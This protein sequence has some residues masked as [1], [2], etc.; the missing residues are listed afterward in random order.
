MNEEILCLY[1]KYTKRLEGQDKVKANTLI[2]EDFFQTVLKYML[3]NDMKLEQEVI[4][5]EMEG[6]INHGKYDCIPWK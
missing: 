5:V 4:A 1:K 2:M 6:E 3:D